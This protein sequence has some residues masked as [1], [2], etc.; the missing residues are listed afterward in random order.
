MAGTRFYRVRS[1]SEQPEIGPDAHRAEPHVE[2]SE[3]NPEEAKTREKLVPAIQA[4]DA[5]VTGPS[6]PGCRDF[7]AAAA[8]QVA[9]RMAAERIARE[10]RRVDGQDQAAQADSKVPGTA[11]VGEPVRLQRIDG[12]NAD[13]NQAQIQKIAVYVLKYERKRPFAQ[14]RFSRF[15]D[16][17][18]RRIGPERLV[19][20]AAVVIAGEPEAARRPQNEE[21]GR[22]GQR[23][24]P[25]RRLRYETRLAAVSKQQRRVEGG[26][27]RAEFE[28][29]ALE[30]GPRRVHDERRKSQEHQERLKPPRI[31]TSCFSELTLGQ[32]PYGLRHRRSSEGTD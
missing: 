1:S 7:I 29:I 22:K 23:T 5:R 20:G 13:E 21:R 16:G 17:A 6:Q 4:G 11:G 10:Q 19:V 28:M 18:R 8:D 27:I 26:E 25:P 15:T 30:G 9:Q 2:V 32:G 3:T 31:A 24:G 14:I 12:Q